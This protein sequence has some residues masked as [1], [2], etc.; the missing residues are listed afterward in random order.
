M[1]TVNTM[2]TRLHAAG[3]MLKQDKCGFM[4]PEV[5]YLGH[6][7]SSQE[8]QPNKEC[9]NVQAPTPT[10]VAAIRCETVSRARKQDM[11]STPENDS[12]SLKLW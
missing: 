5:E 6:T 3:M 8:V 12:L 10:D 9:G 7:I 2:L 1:R 11:T 4:L